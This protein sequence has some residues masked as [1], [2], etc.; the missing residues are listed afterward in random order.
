MTPSYV[1]RMTDRIDANTF[2]RADGVGD[3]QPLDEL[4]VTATFRTRSFARG[5]ELITEIGRL[6]DAMDHHPDVDLRYGSVTLRL[7]THDADG[8]THLDVE[9]ARQISDA[10]RSLGIE[11]VTERP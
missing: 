7:T 6:A 11:P 5:V 9:L 4:E 8:L 3:W 10:A 1:D 2:R